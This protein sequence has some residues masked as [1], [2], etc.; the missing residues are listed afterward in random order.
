MYAV[1]QFVSMI[2]KSAWTTARSVLSSAEALP[3]A[4]SPASIVP[5]RR[6]DL[7]ILFSPS[8]ALRRRARGAG[9]LL[10]DHLLGDAERVDRRR[11]AAIAAGL[12][13][14]LADLVDR[15]PVAQRA[16]DMH[17]ELVR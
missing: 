3:T 2:F 11:P 15:D 4:S 9:V 8:S 1:V 13:E 17:L 10:G 12:D 6:R 7:V 16:A 5:S 14:D